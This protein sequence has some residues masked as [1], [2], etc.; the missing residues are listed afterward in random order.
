MIVRLELAMLP[1]L[2]AVYQKISEQ[3]S[4][5]LSETLLCIYDLVHEK[6]ERKNK[7]FTDVA[8][9]FCYIKKC[10]DR[11]DLVSILTWVLGLKDWIIGFYIFKK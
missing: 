5:I 9:L 10:C 4:G 11:D 7:V 2:S 1:F 3:P 6:T 8:R